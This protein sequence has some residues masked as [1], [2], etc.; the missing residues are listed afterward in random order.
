MGEIIETYQV[1]SFIKNAI[2]VA[3]GGP[4]YWIVSLIVTA[5][6]FWFAYR[7]KQELL[8][9]TKEE[10]EKKWN[11]EKAKNEGAAQDIQDAWDKAEKEIQPP[12]SD[13]P[14]RPR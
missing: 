8:Q 13:L 6:G 1:F 2:T 5:F 3:G 4:M 12:P 11:E 7:F 9:K 10:A 14:R